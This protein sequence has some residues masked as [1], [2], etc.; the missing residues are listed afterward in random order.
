MIKKTIGFLSFSS[1][2]ILFLIPAFFGSLILDKNIVFYPFTTPFQTSVFS[3]VSLWL[4]FLFVH[5]L[6]F[7]ILNL[8]K[9]KDGDKNVV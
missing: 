2:F 4:V 5:D 6:F 1:P 3:V 9:F 7:C 8:V